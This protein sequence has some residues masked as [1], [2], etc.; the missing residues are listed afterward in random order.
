MSSQPSADQTT[1]HRFVDPRKES[2][3]AVGKFTPLFRAYLDHVERWELDADGLTLALMREGLAA[4][5]LHLVTRPLDENIGITVNIKTPPINL[6]LAASPGD[7]TL[8]GRAFTEGVKT[9]ETSRFFLQAYRQTAEPSQSTIDVD[10]LDV[11]GM[12]EDYYARSEQNPG[13]FFDLDDDRF[14][15]VLSLPEAP[16]R[17]VTELDRDG[18]RALLEEPGLQ[19]IEDRHIRF[20]CGCTKEKMLSALHTIFSQSVEELFQGDA[21]VESYCPRCGARWSVTREE[22]ARELEDPPGTDDPPTTG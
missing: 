17:A 19:P 6:F 12:F 22:F 13:R 2:L 9:S 16:D 14:L 4:T 18:A 3:L 7:S 1:I 21:E 8:T 20:H 11:L 10:G 5:A 15:F